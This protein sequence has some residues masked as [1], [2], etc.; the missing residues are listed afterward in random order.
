MNWFFLYNSVFA[1]ELAIHSNP[2]NGLQKD[3][4]ATSKITW[5]LTSF[6]GI[7]TCSLGEMLLGS[8]LS[9]GNT[10]GSIGETTS[11]AYIRANS[12]GNIT[13]D[14]T[15]ISDTNVVSVSEIIFDSVS[16]VH[17]IGISTD[18]ITTDSVSASKLAIDSNPIDG[19]VKD[20]S[21][22]DKNNMRFT[23]VFVIR[24]CCTG[25]ILFDSTLIFGIR[26][27]FIGKTTFAMDI[28]A[29]FIDN[30]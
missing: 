18:E 10:S 16:T 1:S 29:D 8:T 19:L 2:V 3:F 9:F 24:A 26:S 11:V 23:S 15:A 25:E 12:V 20:C 5:D 28:T 27:G 22:T 21:V 6:F 17:F 30:I 4:S 13:S 7:R 14:S